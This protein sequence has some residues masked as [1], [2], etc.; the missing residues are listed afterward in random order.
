MDH[1]TV[2]ARAE[3]L[4]QITEYRAR[5]GTQHP[6]LARLLLQAGKADRAALATLFTEVALR[7]SDQF[8]IPGSD[9]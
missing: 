4:A 6:L 2:P 5:R 1:T 8:R 3:Y 7:L 9:E